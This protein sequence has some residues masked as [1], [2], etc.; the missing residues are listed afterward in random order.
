MMELAQAK[1]KDCGFSITAL[2]PKRGSWILNKLLDK[3]IEISQA[4]ENKDDKDDKPSSSEPSPEIIISTC[5]RALDEET[6]NKVQNYALECVYRLEDV[7]GTLQ[8]MPLVMST[9]AFAIKEYEYDIKA[10][11]F[12]TK[13]VLNANLAPFFTKDELRKI[14]TGQA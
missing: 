13:E 2:L 9:G 6:Y 1:Y 4:N 5:F 14:A 10:V 11:L 7:G 3:L 8:P 12:F